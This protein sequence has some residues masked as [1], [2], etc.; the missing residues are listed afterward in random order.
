MDGKQIREITAEGLTYQTENGDKVFIDFAVCHANYVQNMVSP[1][2]IERMKELN[3]RSQWNDEDI[4]KYIEKVNQW[5]EVGRR[6]VLGVPW[7]DGPYIEFHTDP[8]LRFEFATVDDY[9]KVRYL[10]EQFGWRTM[11][12]S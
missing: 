2:G 4:K 5:K 8:P 1:G 11:D 3:P 9:A 6:N 10:V 7:A 12:L